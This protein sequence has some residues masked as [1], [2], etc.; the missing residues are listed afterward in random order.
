MINKNRKYYPLYKYLLTQS[1]EDVC[2]LSFAEV[3]KIIDNS[4]PASAYKTRAWWANTRT[5]QSAS[6]LDAE[7]VVDYVNFLEK[8]V[9]F[10]PRRIS[11]RLTPAKPRPTW[12]PDK[13][14][15]LREYAGWTQHDL[16]SQLGVRQQTISEWETGQHVPQY[17]SGKHLNLIAKEAGFPYQVEDKA[18]E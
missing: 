18:E 3:E 1:Q 15:A 2:K 6:W 16:A 11:Y 14:K 12:S 5:V 7:W 17:S 13:V 8:W 9:V 4:L 10:R